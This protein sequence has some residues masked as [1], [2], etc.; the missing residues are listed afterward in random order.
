MGC[1][2]NSFFSFSFS[3]NRVI[4]I[5]QLPPPKKK[6]KTWKDLHNINFYVRMT[7]PIS[8]LAHRYRWE[9]KTLGKGYGIKWGAIGNSLWGHIENLENPNGNLR[10]SLGTSH[11]PAILLHI[12]KKQGPQNDEM[13][14]VWTQNILP[15]LTSSPMGMDGL[16]VGNIFSLNSW[17]I[18]NHI[19]YL[20]INHP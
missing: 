6:T 1:L 12:E 19:N 16:W 9:G 7:I 11:P 15:R 5:G 10:T 4:L 3:S 8:L 20:C 14:G 18:V 13:C 17:P 2:P